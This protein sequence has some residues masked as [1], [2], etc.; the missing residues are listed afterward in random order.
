MTDNRPEGPTTTHYN[1][2]EQHCGL[3]RWHSQVMLKS[4]LDPVYEHRCV[5]PSHPPPAWYYDLPGRYIGKS[6]ITP[7]DWCPILHPDKDTE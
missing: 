6:D 7:L 1:Y 4:G 2:S 5:H 3:C